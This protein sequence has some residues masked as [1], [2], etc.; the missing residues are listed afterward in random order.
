MKLATA[1]LTRVSMFVPRR[2]SVLCGAPERLPFPE[3][4]PSSATRFDDSAK[5][6]KNTSS[7]SGFYSKPLE[8]ELKSPCG[9]GNTLAINR[10]M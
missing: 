9:R 2:V 7:Y 3:F 4:P 10:V 6:A 5:D 1:D 8:R